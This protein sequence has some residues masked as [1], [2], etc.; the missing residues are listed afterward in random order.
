MPFW[1]AEPG[2]IYSR[3][4]A[5][6]LVYWLG[7]DKAGSGASVVLVQE[8]LGLVPAHQWGESCPRA[9]CCR[10]LGHQELVCLQGWGPWNWCLPTGEQSWATGPL[11]IRSWGS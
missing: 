10:A 1:W 9:S 11:A 7:S 3:D 5:S 4:D 8:V 2:P 6:L